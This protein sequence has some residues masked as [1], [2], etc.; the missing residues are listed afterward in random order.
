MR[1]SF[2]VLCA[3]SGALVITASL[4]AQ[5]QGRGG[6][7]PTAVPPQ[8]RGVTPPGAGAGRGGGGGQAVENVPPIAT[9]D[10][11][12]GFKNPSRW[13]TNHGDYGGQRFSPLTQITAANASQLAPQWTFQTGV[14]GNFEATPIVLEGTLFFTGPN[15]YAWALD[16]KTGKQI[17]RYVRFPGTPAQFPPNMKVCCGNVNRGFAIY[18]DKLFKT[19]LDAHLIALDAKTGK[20]V[21]DVEMVDYKLGYAGTV[22]PLVVKDK[23]IVGIAGGEFANRGF[24]DAYD[25]ADGKRIWRFWTIPGPGEPGSETWPPEVLKRGGA[26]TWVTGTYDPDLNLIYWGT[27]NPNP[28][29]DGDSRPGDNLYAAA[30]VA[31]DADTGKL[32]WH[33]Q[34][35]PHDTH[36]WDA[37]QVPVLADLT[38]N[39][40]PRK[41]LIQAVRNGYLYVLDRTN[42]K[43]I[44][45]SPF[46]N[47]NWASGFT[48]EGRPIEL[49]GHNPTPQ[50]TLTCPD[51]YGST[52]FNS[53]SY[54]KGRN[55]FFVSTRLTCAIFTSRLTQDAGL[56]V[57]D[58]TMGG[59]VQ[60]TADPRSGALRA[61][62]PLTGQMK[63]EVPYAGPGWAGVMATAGGVVFTADHAGMFMA[64]DSSTGKVLY[65]YQTGGVTYAPPTTYQIDG[66][67]WVVMPSL[68]TVTAFALPAGR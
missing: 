47:P 24:L 41:V 3:I 7:P 10:I 54:D 56:N 4:A 62:D 35:T 15:D 19:T 52:N 32:K 45:A 5:T 20:L 6:T 31:L 58:R 51:W 50:G 23:L 16:A 11:L 55:L 17:W 53:P 34:Y 36:D 33:Y 66:R 8:G 44:K 13:V 60:P 67:Q 57:G 9:K 12:D 1:K 68:A 65:T 30:V 59:G 2:G 25:P 39:G 28:D 18:G 37:N 22:T 27:G 49:P 43:F 46:G 61:F 63:W 48:P 64:V 14:P 38:I 21:W 29:W 42:G 40:Q 26:P